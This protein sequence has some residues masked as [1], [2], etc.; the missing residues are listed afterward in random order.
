MALVVV[1]WKR[2]D[3]S[4]VAATAMGASSTWTLCRFTCAVHYVSTGQSAA[5]INRGS[6]CVV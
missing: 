5:E 1:P 4:I 6:S 3:V 2:S